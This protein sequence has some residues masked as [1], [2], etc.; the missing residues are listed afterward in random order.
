MKCTAK[1]PTDM[2]VLGR[3]SALPPFQCVWVRSWQ[4]D[5]GKAASFPLEM[6]GTRKTEKA[7]YVP[8]LGRVV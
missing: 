1:R 5:R 6:K 4:V 7:A 3:R 8:M 2:L